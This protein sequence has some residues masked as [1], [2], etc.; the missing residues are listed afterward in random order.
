MTAQLDFIRL[1]GWKRCGQEGLDKRDASVFMAWAL[2]PCPSTCPALS[3]DNNSTSCAGLL[4][5]KQKET[6][7]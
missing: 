1:W 7:A 6:L 5:K 4:I 2:A 3:H